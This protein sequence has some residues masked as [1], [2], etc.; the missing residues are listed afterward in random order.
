MGFA[1]GARIKSGLV[2]HKPKRP[3]LFVL[4]LLKWFCREKYHAD[5]EGDIIESFQEN[6]ETRGSR[7]AKWLLLR[8]MLQLFRPGIIK[9]APVPGKPSFG[10]WKNNLKSALRNL[11]K[12]KEYSFV[13]ILGLSMGIASTLLV[14]LYVRYEQ[15]YDKFMPQAEHVFKLVENRTSPEGT[16]FSRTVPYSFARILRENYPE[17]ASATAFSGPYSG[18]QVFIKDAQG[19]RIDFLEDH[20][21]LADDQFL[22][23]FNLELLSGNPATALKEPNSVVLTESTARRFFGD[24]DP[25]G[26]FISAA[27]K[28]SIVTGVCRDLPEN[29]HLKFSYLVSSTSVAWFKSEDFTLR[30]THCYLRLHPE[31]SAGQLQARFPEMVK[32]HMVIAIER[33]NETSWE[34]YQA[35]GNDFHFFLKPLTAIHLDADNPG[36]MKAGGSRRTMNVLIAIAILIF[37]IACVNFV[38]LATSRSAERAREVGVRK[39]MGS[40]RSQLIVQFLTE[41]I[42]LSILSSLVALAIIYMTLPYFNQFVNRQL[43][44]SLDADLIPGLL[45]LGGFVGILAGL[46]PALALSSFK[47]VSVLKGS[48]TTS[49]RGRGFRNGLVIFQFCT[50]IVLVISTLTLQQQLNFM[51]QKDLGF[52]KDQLVIIEGTFDR[53]GNFAEPYLQEIKN[54]P[55][56]SGAAGSLWVQGLRGTRH[57]PYMAEGADHEVNLQRVTMGDDFA[58]VMGLELVSG[59]FFAP[60]MTDSNKVLLNEVA[61]QKLGLEEPVGKRVAMI[62]H[63]NGLTQ[64]T[65]FTV[66]GLIKDFHYASLKEEIAPMIILSNELYANRMSF[67]VARLNS[68][69]P[70][71]LAALEQKWEQMVPDRPFRYRF[72]DEIIDGQYKSEQRNG[73]V[74]SLFASLSIVIAIMG[75]FALSAYTLSI[76]KKEISIRK[77][78]GASVLSILRLLSLD[79]FKMIMV[80]LLIAFPIAWYCMESW[81]NDFAYRINLSPVVFL[82]AGGLILV[83]TWCTISYQSLKAARTNPVKYIHR[84]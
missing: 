51:A 71:G 83:I 37:C 55:Q 48:F 40:Q 63:E 14:L 64:R 5:I 84:D 82:L 15:S 42:A 62:T 29:S 9:P 27:G 18:Q 11:V 12:K 53:K 41:S 80:A 35:A 46:Y 44:F 69:G 72:F 25:L 31:S 23:V 19:Q 8:D 34:A 30:S 26:Q 58:R 61:A 65:Y 74:L 22:S 60:G 54:L 36:G 68:A 17:V 57:E 28:N 81:L 52:D 32:T 50:A 2:K 16:S 20:V 73:K 33:A 49:A 66:K 75:L 13:N 67:I 70:Q 47:P 10:L 45:A 59:A 43:T 24:T 77:V 21:L 7:S 78:V 76:R 6:S 39:V 1:A 56:V 79:F 4:R 3:P 38:N